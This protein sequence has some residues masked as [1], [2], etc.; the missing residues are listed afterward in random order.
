MEAFKNNSYF[1][2]LLYSNNDS[3]KSAPSNDNND[4]N[5]KVELKGNV[6]YIIY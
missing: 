6:Y 4:N 3:N 5:N 2:S 1:Q